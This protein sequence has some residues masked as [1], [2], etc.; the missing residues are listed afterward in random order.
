[1]EK[2]PVISF[3]LCGFMAHF[4]KF[5]TNTSAL[6]YPFPPRTTLMGLIAG[7]LGYR[8]DEYYSE[9][10]S[11]NLWL[12]V[13]MLTYV[14]IRT[15][16]VNYL[17]TKEKKLYENAKGTQIPVGLVLPSPTARIIKYK[18]YV[19]TPLKELW[20]KLEKVFLNK[21]FHWPPY[22]GI[23]EAPGWIE[24]ISI[25]EVPYQNC[26]NP[27]LIGTPVIKQGEINGLIL[28]EKNPLR[29]LFD[30][31]SLDIQNKPYRASLK[32]VDIIYEETGKPFL[33]CLPYKVFLLP[34]TINEKEKIYGVFFKNYL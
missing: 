8:K 27:V 16:T 15:Y 34:E 13:R 22:L 10:N 17:F 24:N 6:T 21:T 32:T 18:I 23:T 14:R 30:K 28:N 20:K 1:M 31:M 25:D 12:S 26:K 29:L 11:E 5:Y 33:I 19:S 2:I 3:V 9:L 4:R 7:L